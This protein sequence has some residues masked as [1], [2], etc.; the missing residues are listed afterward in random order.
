MESADTDFSQYL[1][2]FFMSDNIFR[3]F[4]YVVFILKVINDNSECVS[5]GHHE[6]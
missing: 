6:Y 1:A 4:M 5:L 3:K 2:G